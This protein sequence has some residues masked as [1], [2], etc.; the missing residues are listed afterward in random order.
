M[1]TK[2]FL[3]FTYIDDSV[4]GLMKTI[5]RFDAVKNDIFNIASQ[6]GTSKQKS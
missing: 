2:K 4:T 1:A 5:E 6:K 3:D